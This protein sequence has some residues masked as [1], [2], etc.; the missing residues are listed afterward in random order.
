MHSSRMQTGRSLTIWRGGSPC[1]GVSLPGRVL[2]AGGFSLLGVSLPGGLLGGEGFSLLET[3]PVNR[4]T[5]TCKNITLATTSLRPVR[6]SHKNTAEDIILIRFVQRSKSRKLP[7]E[8]GVGDD[9]LL[10]LK[11]ALAIDISFWTF[12]QNNDIQS[13]S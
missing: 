1:L 13:Q 3:P 12:E 9:I 6:R 11:E 2:P 5:D 7:Q 8:L 10:Q 4:M